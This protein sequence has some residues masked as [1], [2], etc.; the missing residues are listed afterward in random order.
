MGSTE[1]V[2]ELRN[3]AYEYAVVDCALPVILD[4]R[5]AGCTTGEH[6]ADFLNAVGVLAPNGGY[7]DATVSAGQWTKNSANR[8]VQYLIDHGLLDWPRHRGKRNPFLEAK[9]VSGFAKAAKASR[10]KNGFGASHKI[11][12]PKK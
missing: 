11:T 9:R 6:L 2:T 8:A 3:S 5:L 12:G 4:A 7:T 1:A 10:K